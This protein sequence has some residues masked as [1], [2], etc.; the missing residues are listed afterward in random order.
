MNNLIYR[1]GHLQNAITVD[2][3]ALE[4]IEVAFGPASNAYGSD[5]MGGLVQF[6]TKTPLFSG[7]GRRFSGQ[8]YGKYSSATQSWVKHAELS[9][10]SLRW[11]TYTSLTQSDFGGL[12]RWSAGQSFLRQSLWTTTLVRDAWFSG[13]LLGG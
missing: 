8:V 13:R 5:A 7:Q 4:R 2:P 12:A 6:F 1:S 3:L 9:T 11:A 10:S